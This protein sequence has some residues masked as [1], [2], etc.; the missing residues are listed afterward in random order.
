MG[1]D[2]AYYDMN[3]GCKPSIKDVLSSDMLCKEIELA[4]E[5]PGR[6]LRY[7]LKFERLH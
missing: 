5:R 3:L 2:L 1:H 7:S 6:N 4:L